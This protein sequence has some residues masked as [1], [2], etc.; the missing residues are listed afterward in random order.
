[1]KRPGGATPEPSMLSTTI[2]MSTETTT[3]QERID[4]R[5]ANCDCLPS[6]DP[7]GLGC[8]PCYLA[9][10]ETANPNPSEN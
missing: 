3:R 7:D 1:M 8:F 4:G 5:P 6:M 10:F 9:G 2:R